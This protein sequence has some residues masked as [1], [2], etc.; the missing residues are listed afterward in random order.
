MPRLDTLL[1]LHSVHDDSRWKHVEARSVVAAVAKEAGVSAG[2]R[3]A[4]HVSGAAVLRA[5][6]RHKLDPEDVPH[7]VLASVVVA[8]HGGSNGGRAALRPHA[9]VSTN[10]LVCLLCLLCGG[11]GCTS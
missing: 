4:K 10:K 5:L 8:G 3:L 11:G 6:H 2:F 7:V 1:A 9:T